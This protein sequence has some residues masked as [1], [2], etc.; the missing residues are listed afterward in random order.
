[1][2][3]QSLAGSGMNRGMQR[4]HQ[5]MQQFK[6]GQV[7]IQKSDVQDL[8]SKLEARGSPK[9][10]KLNALLE[11][12]DDIDK[13]DDGISIDELKSFIAENA[14][15]AQKGSE[16]RP[17][18]PPPGM[19]I[20]GLK[21]GGMEQA[22]RQDPSQ[23]GITKEA[24]TELKDTLEKQ[25]IQVPEGLTEMIDAFDSIDADKSGQVNIEELMQFYSNDAAGAEGKAKSA[26]ASDAESTEESGSNSDAGNNKESLIRS[27]AR[28]VARSLSQKG[29]S[30]EASE[31]PSLRDLLKQVQGKASEQAKPKE[32]NAALFQKSFQSYSLTSTKISYSQTS[33]LANQ[34]A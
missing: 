31:S 27:V 32:G 4:M 16:Q 9:A 29:S 17:P 3:I 28:S 10:D 18:G 21:P 34:F 20:I 2:S 25:G 33:S 5:Q 24:L 14:P 6:S 19:F 13:N 8:Q 26:A 22:P 1:M 15:K 11:S 23:G 7:N 12:F 30:T